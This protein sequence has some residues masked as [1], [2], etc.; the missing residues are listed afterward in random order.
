MGFS[1]VSGCRELQITGGEDL[2]LAS[3]QRMEL[4]LVANR[5]VQPLV[6]GNVDEP[7]Y[8]SSSLIER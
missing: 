4:R 8:E 6:I 7:G 2:F 3:R 5:A 1:I